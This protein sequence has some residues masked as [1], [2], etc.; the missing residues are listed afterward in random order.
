MAS[1]M[2]GRSS[3]FFVPSYLM[4]S[5]YIERLEERHK[6]RA[7]ALAKQRENKSGPPSR[8]GSLSTTPSS[9]NLRGGFGSSSYRG[10][11]FDIVEKPSKKDE[12]TTKPLPRRWNHADKWHGLELLSDGLEVKSTDIQKDDAASVRA[13]APVPKEC[14]I[15]YYEITV[16]GKSKEK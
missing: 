10:V 4:N 1:M 15:Y 16:L 7:A 3:D 11:A 8:V 6:A 2:S 5:R 9:M 14:G 13:D 12:D